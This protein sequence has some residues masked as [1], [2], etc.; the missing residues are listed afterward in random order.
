MYELFGKQVEIKTRSCNY[1]GIAGGTLPPSVNLFVKVTNSCNANCAFCSNERERSE[2]HGFDLDKLSL[3]ID[4]IMCGNISLNRINITGGEPSCVKDR[5]EKILG[6][7]SDESHKDIH[8][9]LNTNGLLHSSQELMRNQRWNSISISLHHYDRDRLSE[10]YRTSIPEDALEFRDID[11]MK[12]NVSCNL[13]KGYIDSQE[14]AHR[15]MDLCIDKGISRLGFVGLMKVND[16]CCQHFVDLED[17]HLDRIPHCY[18]TESRDRGKD[19]MCSNYL[20]NRDLKVLDVYMRHY[21]NPAYCE[22]SLLYDGEF[23]RQG[24]H[25]NNIIC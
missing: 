12:V 16:F 5:V 9:H 23:L 7:M 10:L 2:D 8:L 18:F 15:M 22:S 24:F 3:I 14:G 21:V 17:L 4:E 13:I 6:R 19:C 1:C 25:S 20:Y 11:M